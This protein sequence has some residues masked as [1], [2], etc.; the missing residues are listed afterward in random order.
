MT[1]ILPI[2]GVKHNPINQ[3]IN[4]PS[5]IYTLRDVRICQTALFVTAPPQPFHYLAPPPILPFKCHLSLLKAILRLCVHV[6]E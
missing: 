5:E 1:E 4:Q 2:Y 6:D 3:L